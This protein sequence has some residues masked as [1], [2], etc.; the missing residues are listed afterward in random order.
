[1]V[2]R[3]CVALLALVLAASRLEAQALTGVVLD[4]SL[5][6]PV[7]GARLVLLDSLGAALA[8]VVTGSDGKFSFNLPRTGQYR[9]LVSRIGYPTITTKR[10]VVD[11]V[12]TARVSLTLP[13]TPLTLDTVTIVGREVERRLQYL[14][15]AGFYRRKRIGFGHF[16]TRA[17][18]DKLDA[19][20]MSDLL[21]DMPGVRVTCT[22]PRSCNITMRTANSMFFRGKCE[23]SIVLDGVLLRAGGVG[24]RGDISLDGLISPFNVE[25]IEV[26]PGPE[27]VPIQYAG[28]CG[29]IILWSRR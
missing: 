8:V 10:F 25:A 22:G 5:K 6:T 12:F 27:G 15:D 4:S 13:S 18:I 24:G 7:V 20:I 26:Y 16:L 14:E 19:V 29:A 9:L 11:S 23:P 17:Q 2:R 21:H 3:C 1:M 28:P